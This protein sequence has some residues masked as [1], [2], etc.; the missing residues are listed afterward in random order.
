L[1]PEFGFTAA[2]HV[3]PL[4]LTGDLVFAFG[5]MAHLV[6]AY[7]VSS[8]LLLQANAWDCASFT[9]DW[10]QENGACMIIDWAR[11]HLVNQGGWDFPGG[12]R[13]PQEV[14]CQ[15]AERRTLEETGLMVQAVKKISANVF[16]CNLQ[17][18]AQWGYD[19]MWFSQ[20]Q[21]FQP[22]F[23]W[24]PNT[25]GD[26]LGL[27]VENLAGNP[28]DWKTACGCQMCSGY[29][30]DGWQCSLNPPEIEGCQCHDWEA[31]DGCNCRPCYGEGFS[32]HTGRCESGSVTNPQEECQCVADSVLNRINGYGGNASAN[33]ANFTFDDGP[34]YG[35]ESNASPDKL[36]MHI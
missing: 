34:V 2:P 25:W 18:T 5:S 1:A 31:M 17:Y 23:N 28:P 8:V 16:I 6:L 22:N 30:Y 27:I 35:S 36:G 29:G 15:T 20:E 3:F 7:A 33:S 9:G 26:K 12:Y 4:P 10:S 32:H 19:A 24:R 11:V 14:T 13:Q 21:M